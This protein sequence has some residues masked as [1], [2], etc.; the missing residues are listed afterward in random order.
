[1]HLK[2][3]A[4]IETAKATLCILIK[5]YNKKIIT[6]LNQ[7][8]LNKFSEVRILALPDKEV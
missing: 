6:S 1:M 7:K 8:N 4:H 3:E 5:L 2:G